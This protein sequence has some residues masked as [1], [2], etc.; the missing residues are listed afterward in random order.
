MRAKVDLPEPEF[1]DDAERLA[2]PDGEIEPVDGL[3]QA[4]RLMLDEPRDPGL[5]HVED[6]AELRDLDRAA[7]RSWNGPALSLSP[8]AGRGLG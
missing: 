3:Q 7:R 2:A 4:A 1:A 8:P 6:A 5:R